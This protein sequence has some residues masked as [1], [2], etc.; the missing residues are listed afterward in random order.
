MNC[1]L[2]KL[3]SNLL[4]TSL[5]IF[6]RCLLCLCFYKNLCRKRS[7]DFSLSLRKKSTVVYEFGGSLRFGL[8]IIRTRELFRS[9]KFHSS[10][11]LAEPDRSYLNIR[12]RRQRVCVTL[13]EFQPAAELLEVALR[14]RPAAN[15]FYRYRPATGALAKLPSK[16]TILL[17]LIVKLTVW[18]RGSIVAFASSRDSL[19]RARC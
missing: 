11:V 2:N 19:L 15:F 13:A 3:I 10:R 8:R 9:S 5:L 14:T 1:L 18:F 12:C 16:Q 17:L 6:L 4:Y 7:P